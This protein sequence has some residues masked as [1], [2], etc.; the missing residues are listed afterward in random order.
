MG[1]KKKKK[2][3]NG[4]WGGGGGEGLGEKGAKHRHTGLNQKMEI[5]TFW[6]LQ[7]SKPWNGVKRVRCM[8]DSWGGGEMLAP[9]LWLWVNKV[10]FE[11]VLFEIGILDPLE[12]I[13]ELTTSPPPC[14]KQ[15]DGQ[16]ALNNPPPAIG[17]VI[18]GPVL[19]PMYIN[20]YYHFKGRGYKIGHKT[21]FYALYWW[22]CK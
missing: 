13:E 5:E 9:S 1:Q 19:E 14:L 21:N 22:K 15:D 6:V 11:R 20:E 7:L 12:R 10:K 16:G 17:V 4:K 3:G 2:R 18:I 8:A